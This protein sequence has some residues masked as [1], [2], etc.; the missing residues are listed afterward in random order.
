MPDK[1]LTQPG[2]S[3]A[4]T[5]WVKPLGV[6]PRIC[7]APAGLIVTCLCYK[8]VKFFKFYSKAL[9]QLLLKVLPAAEL[10]LLNAKTGL[11]F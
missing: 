6:R 5:P 9:K 8:Q 4:L 7:V 3:P 2:V 10:I 11:P 1:G